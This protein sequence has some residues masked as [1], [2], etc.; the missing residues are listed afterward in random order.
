VGSH[1]G[2]SVNK[3]Q[4]FDFMGVAILF[5]FAMLYYLREKVNPWF[6]KVCLFTFLFAPKA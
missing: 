6:V 2:F 3:L 1:W 5:S 4:C